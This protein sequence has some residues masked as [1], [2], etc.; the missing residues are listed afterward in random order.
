MNRYMTARIAWMGLYLLALCLWFSASTVMREHFGYDETP[1][2]FLG[3]FFALFIFADICNSVSARTTHINPFY[4]LSRNR[5]FLW[6]FSFIIAAQL[7]MIRF[8]GSVFRTCPLPVGDLFLILGLA[9]TVLLFGAV[10]KG[11]LSLRFGHDT[12]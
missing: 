4:R 1:V 9:A 8:G 11:M 3:A 10:L 2:R 6:I 7:S 5:A 12:L